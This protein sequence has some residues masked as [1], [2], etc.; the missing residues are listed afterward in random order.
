LTALREFPKTFSLNELA[1]GYFPY[2]FNTDDNQNY[3]GTYPD[4]EYYGEMKKKDK[5]EFDKW[6]ETT[7]GKI[8]NFKE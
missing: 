1:K 3:I 5:D 8:F 7:E 6:Y 4:K 2:K